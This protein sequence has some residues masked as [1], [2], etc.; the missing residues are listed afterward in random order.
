M[1]MAPCNVYCVESVGGDICT[2]LHRVQGGSDSPIF[3]NM[4]V[5]FQV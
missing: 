5:L 4:G 2:G 1:E 3:T